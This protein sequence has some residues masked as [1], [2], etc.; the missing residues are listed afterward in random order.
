MGVMLWQLLAALGAV[1]KL[2]PVLPGP[3]VPDVAGP[4]GTGR[5]DGRAVHHARE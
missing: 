2:I 5:E 1:P 3:G 4:P